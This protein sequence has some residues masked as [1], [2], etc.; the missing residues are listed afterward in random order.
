MDIFTAIKERRSCR[1]Y[2]SNPIDE[3]TIEKILEAAGWAP[4]AANNQPWEFIVISNSDV[5]KEIFTESEKSRKTL[6]EKSGWKWIDR[7][8]LGFLQ[9]APVL[10]AVVGDP[11]KTGADMFLEGGGLA[12]QHGCAAA[13]QNML[14]A[15]H[16]Y[17][18]GSL[19]F[20]LFEKE[21]L[22]KILNIPT[23]KDPLALICLGKAAVAPVQTPRKEVKEKVSYI[24]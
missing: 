24:R 11:Q 19:W 5:K 9:E 14:L 4:S 2:L 23:E 12:Y 21:S 22:R 6:F 15:A 13:V 10:I 17:G 18:L 8:K 16:A 7:Y 20:T 3:E 1:N